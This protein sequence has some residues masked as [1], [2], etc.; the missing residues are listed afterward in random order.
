MEME[1]WTRLRFVLFVC[2]LLFLFCFGKVWE[3]VEC[4]CPGSRPVDLFCIK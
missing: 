2:F 4:F 1:A 3:L